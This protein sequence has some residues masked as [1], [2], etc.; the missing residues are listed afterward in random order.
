MNKQKI[1]VKRY[2]KTSIAFP[3]IGGTL[4]AGGAIAGITIGIMNLPKVNAKGGSIDVN[5]V[6]R[7]GEFTFEFKDD[8]KGD[9][10]D[11]A[12]IVSVRDKASNADTT[13]EVVFFDEKGKPTSGE[14]TDLLIKNNELKVNIGLINAPSKKGVYHYV[15]DVEFWYTTPKEEQKHYKVLNLEIN[16]VVQQDT[17]I[18]EEAPE[19]E[20]TQ[21]AEVNHNENKVFDIKGFKYSGDVIDPRQ[22]TVDV[23][24]W[25]SADDD[26]AEPTAYIS[27]LDEEEKTFDVSI[28]TQEIHGANQGLDNDNELTGYLDIKFMQ[29]DVI[30]QSSPFKFSIS[31]KASVDE[32]EIDTINIQL[33]RNPEDPYHYEFTTEGTPFTWHGMEELL[34][35]PGRLQIK[36]TFNMPTGFLKPVEVQPIW[37]EEQPSKFGLKFIVDLIENT[38]TVCTDYNVNGYLQY[39]YTAEGKDPVTVNGKQNIYIHFDAFKGILPPYDAMRP[40]TI[41]L[42]LDESDNKTATGDILYTHFSSSGVSSYEKGDFRVDGKGAFTNRS[43]EDDTLEVVIDPEEPNWDFGVKLPDIQ[44]KS[45]AEW[46]QPIT[47]DF[48]FYKKNGDSWDTLYYPGN[49]PSPEYK[50]FTITPQIEDHVKVME[51]ATKSVTTRMP[52]SG[53]K[54]LT[55][56]YDRQIMC[57]GFDD[58]E[59][60]R[61]A[62]VEVEAPGMTANAKIKFLDDEQVGETLYRKANLTITVNVPTTFTDG[63]I[64]FGDIKIYNGSSADPVATL[65]GFKAEVKEKFSIDDENVQKRFEDVNSL[66]FVATNDGWETNEITIGTETNPFICTGYGEPS[67]IPSKESIIADS[68]YVRTTLGGQV[69]VT[70][71]QSFGDTGDKEF[72]IKLKITATVEKEALTLQDINDLAI[73]FKTEGETTSQDVYTSRG[74]YLAINPADSI[75]NKDVI[76]QQDSTIS[77]DR[78]GMINISGYKFTGYETH[79]TITATIEHEHAES[80]EAWFVQDD[81]KAPVIHWNDEDHKFN[82]DFFIKGAQGFETLERLHAS[83]KL[84]VDGKPY[85]NTVDVGF[86]SEVSFNAD[87]VQKE[88]TLEKTSEG[89]QMTLSNYIYNGYEAARATSDIKAFYNAGDL[90]LSGGTIV[91]PISLGTNDVTISAGNFVQTGTSTG[92]F[93]VGILVKKDVFTNLDDG[94]YTIDGSF[95]VGSNSEQ[96]LRIS[97]G[98]YKL[99]VK[100]ETPIYQLEVSYDPDAPAPEAVWDTTEGE[101]QVTMTGFTWENP[102]DKDINKLT[103]QGGQYHENDVRSHDYTVEWD[104]ETDHTLKVKFWAADLSQFSDHTIH[105]DFMQFK[106]TNGTEVSSSTCYNG[107][108]GFNVLL[109]HEFMILDGDVLPTTTAIYDAEAQKWNVFVKGFRANV[110]PTKITVNGEFKEDDDVVA[111]TL[112][113]EKDTE[114][115]GDYIMVHFTVPGS[116]EGALDPEEEHNIVASELEFTYTDTE[117]T[118]TY[119]CDRT[120]GYAVTLS[121][122]ALEVKDDNLTAADVAYVDGKWNVVISGFT[123]DVA[124]PTGLHAAGNFKD[125][126]SGE[127]IKISPLSVNYV[128]GV[129]QVKFT[130]SG[131]DVPPTSD[132]TIAVANALDF[133]Y[134]DQHCLCACEGLTIKLLAEQSDVVELNFTHEAEMDEMDSEEFTINKDKK[135]KLIID[136]RDVTP[137]PLDGSEGC[138]ALYDLTTSSHLVCSFEILSYKVNGVPFTEGNIDEPKTYA[139]DTTEEGYTECWNSNDDL[140]GDSVFE[141]ELRFTNEQEITDTLQFYWYS[142]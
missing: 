110:D 18:V 39:V 31:E 32:T 47:G 132:H 89:Y 66:K 63:T 6:K 55:L 9:Q 111:D 135:Y 1:K 2:K 105:S 112:L 57:T 30:P 26:I 38:A 25:H 109:P 122:K 108:T 117:T 8:V 102:E 142:I 48:T 58:A 91:D 50:E 119:T 116:G 3:I 69:I 73:T 83:V 20:F 85:T 29:M 7:Y 86:T 93:S 45:F 81:E 118:K 36:N 133:T 61:N 136:L 107:T 106:Y 37:D 97:A 67:Y 95:K 5:P 137:S 84:V 130:V 65:T 87:Q 54:E 34:D 129:Y 33:A 72:G 127:T 15:F 53:S 128:E 101:W 24:D 123:S 17:I 103:C 82:I 59:Q 27:N 13:T 125:T 41:K 76:K 60:Q 98:D 80:A 124:V 140:A 113:V 35:N 141:I 11:V 43:T 64:N 56:E 114:A 77:I 88:V 71:V 52:L 134:G 138:L 92:T 12:K 100:K 40:K 70:G 49:N 28:S 75:N 79:P 10:I 121:Q 94:D 23:K 51:G 104:S 62:R 46:N 96:D 14:E 115:G 78:K 90:K 21:T 42:A 126:T 120:G 4:L 139:M 74:Y 44:I 131:D 99:T 19:S 22:I 16:Y 68:D